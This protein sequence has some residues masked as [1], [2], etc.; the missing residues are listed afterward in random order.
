MQ[1]VSRLSDAMKLFHPNNASGHY[2][3]DLRR[4]KNI[5]LKLAALRCVS[6]RF[7]FPDFLKLGMCFVGNRA[8]MLMNEEIFPPQGPM[9]NNP[10]P[11]RIFHN[12][13]VNGAPVEMQRT[14]RI[15]DTGILEVRGGM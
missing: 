12:L 14:W 1:V 13:K 10:L 6:L 3:L 2:R 4:E 9:P 8:E 15:P 5:A 7:A 11:E